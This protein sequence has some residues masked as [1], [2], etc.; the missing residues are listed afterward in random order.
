MTGRK[1]NP[2][3]S[4]GVFI[5]L[6]AFLI[7]PAYGAQ[8]LKRS[9][10]Y[11]KLTAKIIRKIPLPQGYHE[12]LFYDGNSIWVANGKAGNI[13]VIDMVSG[14]MTAEI[15]PIAG[16]TEGI[17]SSPDGSLIVTDWYE[18]KLYRARV[19]N[20]RM[21]AKSEV[22]T[23]PAYPAG[24]ACARGRIFIVTWKRG[25]FGTVF[26]LLEMSE[27]LRIVNSIN[28]GKIQEPAHLAWDGKYLWVTS[29]YSRRVYKMDI[30]NMRI[31]GYFKSPV[32][33]PTG[34]AWDS[35]HLWLTGTYGDLY[36]MQVL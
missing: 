34:I 23:S 19:E 18:K 27:D 8:V 9:K 26:S 11:R 1:T 29:W 25:W 6:S 16:F 5:L 7:M 36:Q 31:E 33:K 12:G 15:K 2:W 24:V 14:S 20:G 30:E 22:S 3:I 4:L 13:W 35:R 32:A 10:D 17:T 28:I 21:L